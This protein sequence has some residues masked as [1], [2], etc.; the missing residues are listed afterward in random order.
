MT[1][2]DNPSRTADYGTPEWTV[3]EGV[4]CVVCPGCAF[5]FDALHTDTGSDGYSCPCC[6]FGRIKRC[7]CPRFT[8]TG[9]FRIAD[10]ACPVH[11][12]DGTEPGD[13]YWEDVSPNDGST[14]I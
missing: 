13:G 3:E 9:G 6:G 10:L 14:A 11:G 8:D 12:V 4:R 5:T 7:I 2:N 1:D